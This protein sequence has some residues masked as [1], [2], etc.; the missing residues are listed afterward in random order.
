MAKAQMFSLDTIIAV[1]AFII[2]ILMGVWIRDYSNEKLYQTEIR[3]DIEIISKNALST[4]LQTP[5]NPSNWTNLSAD[6]FTT[7]NII[8]LGMAKTATYNNLDITEK[9]KPTGMG[10]NTYLVLD[11]SKIQRLSNLNNQKY[12]TYKKL[13]GILG[14]QY[15][16]EIRIR[17]WQ[18]TNYTTQYTIGLPPSST[19]QNI[20]RSDRYALLDGGTRANIIFYLW[21]EC[22][23]VRC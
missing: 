15:E 22:S 16:F 4:L 9:G 20:V 10:I 3:G 11:E 8:S 2:I 23:G 19:A 13:L 7:T 17:P 1:I 12:E 6:D 18:G 5:G 14:P 21:M